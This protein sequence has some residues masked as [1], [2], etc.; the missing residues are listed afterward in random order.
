[1]V[2]SRPPVLERAVP[3]WSCRRYAR[4]VNQPQV[5]H[6]AIEVV[7]LEERALAHFFYSPCF[8]AGRSQTLRAMSRGEVVVQASATS[9]A[10]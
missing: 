10:S 8:M 9:L 5:G 4:E 2:P 1:M 6:S 3:I 7:I